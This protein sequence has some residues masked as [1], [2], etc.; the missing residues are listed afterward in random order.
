M[1]DYDRLALD[2]AH[3]FGDADTKNIQPISKPA[4]AKATVEDNVSG[5]EL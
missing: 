1:F 5:G 4:S 2:V 3:E